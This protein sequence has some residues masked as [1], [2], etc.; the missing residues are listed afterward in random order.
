MQSHIYKV[1]HVNKLS[2]KISKFLD[3]LGIVGYLVDVTHR[4]CK[5][6]RARL[7]AYVSEGATLAQAANKC[8]AA[9]WTVRNACHEHG[10]IWERTYTGAGGRGVH[11]FAVLA[12]LQEGRTQQSVA[13]DL[14]LTRQRV[15]QIKK[16]AIEFGVLE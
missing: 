10:V 4:E 9:I 5:L 2:R 6:L 1:T 14:G 3:R 16:R 8:G 15:Q 7:A 12:G 13:D 11:P